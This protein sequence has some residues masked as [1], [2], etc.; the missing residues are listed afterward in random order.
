M[1]KFNKK[2]ISIAGFKQERYEFQYQVTYK[3]QKFYSGWDWLYATNL[4]DAR[5]FVQ[6]RLRALGG[7]WHSAIVRRKES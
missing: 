7:K 5:A 2:E 6:Q 4:V 1:Q 3:K